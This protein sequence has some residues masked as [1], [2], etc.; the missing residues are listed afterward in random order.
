MEIG[1][2]VCQSLHSAFE[3]NEDANV[4]N[5][6]PQNVVTFIHERHDKHH[7]KSS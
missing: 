6:H 1:E 2:N 4:G 3:I 7:D 5:F